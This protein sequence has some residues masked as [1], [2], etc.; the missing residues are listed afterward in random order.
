MKTP[1]V[2][3][4]ELAELLD[5]PK[6][7]VLDASPA[8]NVSGLVSALEGLQ[9]KGARYFNL[10]DN[11]SDA[12]SEYP[13]SIPNAEQFQEEARKLGVRKDST[14]VV[15]DNL[16]IYTAPRVWWLFNTFGH[17][18]IAVLDGGL[19]AWV[20]AGYPTEKITKKRVSLGNFTAKLNTAM[21]KDY[22]AVKDNVET[23]NE[24]VVDARSSGRFN[25]TAPEP[26]EGLRSGSIPNSVNI[27]FENVLHEGKYKTKEDLTEIFK[28][29]FAA[30]KP[31]VFS[32][33]S[34]LTACIILL[35]S[36][37]LQEKTASVYDG[38][39]TEWAQLEP[40]V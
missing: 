9:I 34:G 28:E 23:G 39:W 5:D 37:L 17:K 13:N 31:L 21:V 4:Q 1:I 36:T 27:P 33:G 22:V 19:P 20:A 12:N 2:T 7:I 8:T 35:A 11:F 6:L 26:R 24:L 29:V 38:S 10:K 40:N 15:Y 16:G 32:C 30:D 18:N 14:I 3:S 25:G